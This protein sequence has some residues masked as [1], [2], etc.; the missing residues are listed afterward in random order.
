VIF[1]R[2]EK[3]REVRSSE[4][5]GIRSVSFLLGASD[6]FP[7]HPSL[8]RSPHIFSSRMVS[9]FFAADHSGARVTS[10]VGR[11][12]TIN[13]ASALTR[14]YRVAR[15]SVQRTEKT[16][17]ARPL[18]AMSPSVSPWQRAIPL[19]VLPCSSEIYSSLSWLATPFLPSCDV[20]V[21]EAEKSTPA[22]LFVRGPRYYFANKSP[23]K[24]HRRQRYAI[25]R[26]R[27]AF[28]LS[29]LR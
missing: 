15:G 14:I 23:A 10:I 11:Y 9:L 2:Y 25:L 8:P 24:R 22:L 28:N 16:S 29:L 1:I 13:S 6:L 4:G 20:H 18:Y 5:C 19:S 17:P 3:L 21:R 27:I 7:A 26:E 12:S